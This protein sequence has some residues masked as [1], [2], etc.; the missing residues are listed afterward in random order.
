MIH[1]S[2]MKQIFICKNMDQSSFESE[3][4]LEYEM[5]VNE[6]LMNVDSFIDEKL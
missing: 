3:V 6:A 1:K 2:K 4:K 5:I